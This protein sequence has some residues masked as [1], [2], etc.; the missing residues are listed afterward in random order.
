MP[1][2]PRPQ[3]RSARDASRGGDTGDVWGGA[4][5]LLEGDASSEAEVD[6]DAAARADELL[7]LEAIYSD[8]MCQVEGGGGRTFEL[9]VPIELEAPLSLPSGE[10][11]DALPPLTLRVRHGSGY[12]SSSPPGFGL[13]CCWLSDGQLEALAASLDGL[14]AAAAGE[15]CVSAWAEWL[16]T[17]AAGQLEL[18]Q[19]GATL[20]LPA[21]G[22]TGQAGAD[23]ATASAGERRAQRWPRSRAEYASLD[24][25]RLHACGHT[26]CKSCLRGYWSSQLREGHA[27]ALLCPH[28]GC[29]AVASP[30]EAKALLSAGEYETYE[31]LLL[32]ASL[33]E[34]TDTSW[35][36]RCEYPAQLE[37]RVEG[38][39]GR[40]AICGTRRLAIC[41]S[42]GTSFC[43]E[44]RQAW[45]GISP[46]ANLAARWRA[47]D[48]RGRETLRQKYGD[49]LMEEANFWGEGGRLLAA[50]FARHTACPK[51]G[52]ATEKNGGCN[53]ISCRTCNF[54]WCWLCGCKYEPGHYKNGPCEQFS[55]DFFDEIDMTPEDFRANYVVMN[56][57]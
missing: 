56:H 49:R 23:E 24:C 20:S 55:Q 37:P 22:G 50:S 29:G 17:E 19:E 4:A 25:T 44:C 43:A 36:P 26:F 54:E 40:V 57:Q 48:E 27:T 38:R 39:A 7:A 35:C 47:S 12:P 45:H 46:C 3:P 53:H 33:A 6:A 21:E 10:R 14:A 34:M 8:E 9:R 30:P 13:R 51:C 11:L 15:L 2:P 18:L 31:R 5:A 28:P 41:A 42:C 32:A 1:L 52:V 16:R